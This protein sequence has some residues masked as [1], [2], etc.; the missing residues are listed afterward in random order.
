MQFYIE[1]A[2]FRQNNKDE[3]N[4]LDGAVKKTIVA[5]TLFLGK[6]IQT[7]M[8]PDYLADKL[9]AVSG[10]DVF[11]VNGKQY[12]RDGS[13]EPDDVNMNTMVTVTINVNEKTVMGLNVDDVGITDSDDMSTKEWHK[14]YANNHTANFNFSVPAGYYIDKMSIKH[15]PASLADSVIVSVSAST[16]GGAELG[17]AKVFKNGLIHDIDV[18]KQL[19]FDSAASIYVTLSEGAGA[20]LHVEAIM[21]LSNE[22]YG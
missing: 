13:V 8:I 4:V 21:Q 22:N 11:E 19:A 9:T 14:F 10:L 18:R 6:K 3:I 2:F 5:S 20:D 1:A 16:G 12:I 17:K 15:N 7:A